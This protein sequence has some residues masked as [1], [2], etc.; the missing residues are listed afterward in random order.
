[1][2]ILIFLI[3]KAQRYFRNEL[4]NTVEAQ[5]NSAIADQYI[6]TKSKR[7]LTSAYKIS[8]AQWKYRIFA[9]FDQIGISNLL[10][11]ADAIFIN[12][13]IEVKQTQVQ[14]IKWR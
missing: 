8:E 6:G 4:F 13:T 14:S 9:I 11:K 3:S 1:M 10:K 2:I 5:R 12:I 7:N